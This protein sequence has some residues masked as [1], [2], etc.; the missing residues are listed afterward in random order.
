M[1]RKQ[2]KYVDKIKKRNKEVKE[3]IKELLG[4]E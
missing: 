4:I 1:K 2:K 3:R